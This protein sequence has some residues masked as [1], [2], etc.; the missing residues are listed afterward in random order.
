MSDDQTSEWK[1]PA[2]F[3]FFRADTSAPG[4]GGFADE[5]PA[6]SAQKVK[7]DRPKAGC[8]PAASTPKFLTY[9]PEG[10]PPA[11]RDHPHWLIA[12]R[13]GKPVIRGSVG[14]SKTTPEHWADFATASRIAESEAELWPYIVLTDDSDLTV[15]DVDFKPQREEETAT[16]YEERISRA[17]EALK[18]LREMF[19]A[20]YES[21][22]KSGNGFHII[23][24][25]KFVGPGG[26]GKDEWADV[27]IY[28]RGHGIALTGHVSDGHNNPSPYSEETIQA[29]RD[30]IK[31]SAP[32]VDTGE[33]KPDRRSNGYVRPEWAREVL[34]KIA[35]VDPRPDRDKWLKVS[36]AAFDGVGVVK[37]IEL[38]KEVW[39]E[40]E[41]GEY[42]TLAR[43]LREYIPWGTLRA[44]GIDPDDPED[45]RTPKSD[46]EP[47]KKESQA[48]LSL[49]DRAYALRFDPSEAPPPDELCMVIGDIP[50]AARGNITVPQG[51]SKVG[52]SAVVSAILGA[53]H[54][55]AVKADGDTIC[56]SWIGESTG[57]II[58]FDTEQSRAD[59]H[60][61]VWRGIKRSGIPE[62]SER[63]VSLPL[64]MFSRSE[65]LT[66]LEETLAFEMRAKGKIDLVIIDGVADLCISPNDEAVALELVSRLH[67][68]AQK[69]NCAIVCVLHE[70][71]SSENGK[72][73]GHLG[74]ELNRKAFANLRIDKDTETSVST[75]YGTDMRKRDIPKKQGFCFAW[76]EAA[77]MHTFQ[78][79]AEGVKAERAKEKSVEKARTEW[80]E[81]F[82]AVGFWANG[83]C[84]A[85]TPEQA[86]EAERD[87]PGTKKTVTVAAM[88]KRM[89]RAESLGVLRK[90]GTGAW[91]LNP[92]GQ[93]GQNRDI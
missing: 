72:T 47:P 53:V 69:F 89:Q 40:E 34:V 30:E 71:P 78:G 54:R 21:R 23:V 36:S 55:G 81:I 60:S 61:L 2:E 64:V 45:R 58:H 87:I 10:I 83:E 46:P 49:R 42:Q 12:N 67:A 24:Q 84:P 33:G 65:R 14:N 76:N 38:L 13:D 15:F 51:K 19:P 8:S 22:S 43:T 82:E 3:G 28:T 6:S 18:R 5:N 20:R 27:E 66:I 63:L 62:V 88:K 57:A 56:I 16:Q 37:G 35:K 9:N 93:S 32:T 86:I 31:G 90:A 29:I 52:K 4:N 50:I 79:R 85:L 41:T 70:N 77:R 11:L 26:K 25:G 74:S 68:L 44:Y 73:R 39:P 7:D 48:K 80:R 17:E 59:W 1:T 91:T 92:S 75:I